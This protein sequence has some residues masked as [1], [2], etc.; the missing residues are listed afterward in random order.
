MDNAKRQEFL[1]LISQAGASGS[2]WDAGE[3]MGLDRSDTE[4]LATDLMSQGL[5]EMVSLD[6]KLSVTS[7]G[8]EVMNSGGAAS[9]VPSVDLT[10]LVS[11]L[12]AVGAAGLSGDKAVDLLADV[13]C[14][15]AQL[16]R[17]KPLDIVVQACLK[18]VSQ[19]LA[20]SS[21]PD[22]QNL[23]KQAERFLA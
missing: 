1:R 10:T 11:S 14:L 12:R 5:L 13:A 4:A 22:A 20:N 21:Q 8:E 9:S 23:A 19:A 6:G 16:E 17:S 7:S 2:M 18:T 3:A 15:A